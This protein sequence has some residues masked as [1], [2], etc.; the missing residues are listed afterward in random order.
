MPPAG[1]EST[2][3]AAERRQTYGTGLLEILLIL[4][5]RL[6]LSRAIALIASSV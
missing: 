6:G 5:V 4:S 3:S 1:F 2:I